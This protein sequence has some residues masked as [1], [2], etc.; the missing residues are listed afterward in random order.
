MI[1]QGSQMIERRGKNPKVK[2]KYVYE[3]IKEWHRGRVHR[4]K[5]G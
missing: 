1:E 4:R 5:Y 2:I 3:E